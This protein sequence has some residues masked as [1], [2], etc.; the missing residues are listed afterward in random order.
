MPM[1]WLQRPSSLIKR[2]GK[3]KHSLR[4][5]RKC[6]MEVNIDNCSKSLSDTVIVFYAEQVIAKP[7]LKLPSTLLTT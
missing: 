1:A 7:P 5:G 6:F 2:G 4:E 3:H